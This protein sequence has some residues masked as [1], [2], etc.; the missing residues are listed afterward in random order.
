VSRTINKVEVQGHVGRDAE[1]K[2]EKA[3]VRFSVA[4]GHE[5]KSDGSGKYPLVFHDVTAWTK[6][7][8]DA[9][10]IKKGEYVRVVGRL[11][12]TKWTGKDG[13]E[14]T[15]KADFELREIASP[16]NCSL[17]R[18]VDRDFGMYR[19]SALTAEQVAIATSS[20]ARRRASARRA[21]IALRNC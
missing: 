12:Y 2:S 14:H 9:I 16:Q 11:N 4:T 5:N 6:Q 3:P 20:N 21:S 18:R 7:F 10:N 13:L 8:P 1:Q 17:L 15:G 19:A